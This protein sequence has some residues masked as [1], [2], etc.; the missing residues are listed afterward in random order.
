MAIGQAV[1]EDQREE[2]GSDD[3]EQAAD[4]GSE[5]TLQAEGAH[6]QLKEDDERGE[7]GADAGG[8]PLIDAKRAKEPAS[9][10][11]NEYE[12]QTKSK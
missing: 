3:A 9:S 8:G 6:A 11:K 4:D 5:E 2:E 10:R 7:D 1:A 12:E